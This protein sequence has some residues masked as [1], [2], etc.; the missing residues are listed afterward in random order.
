MEKYKIYIAD[1][2][3][4]FRKGMVRLLQS[5]DNVALV[6]DAENGKELIKLVKEEEPHLVL[7]DLEMPIMDGK[8]ASEYLLGKYEDL[9][10]VV[11][12]MHGSENL[13]YQM[14][15]L[16]IHS[17]LLKNAEPEEVRKAIDAVINNDFY[18][19]RLMREV[20]KKAE[21][22]LLRQK[23]TIGLEELTPREKEIIILI[24]HELTM[25]EIGEKLF[26]SERTVEKHRQ[27][28]MQKLGV[29]NAVGIVKFAFENNLFSAIN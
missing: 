15:Q 29:K 20:I 10:I 3:T 11:L 26:L 2:H 18:Y 22:G 12:S 9:K 8:T 13:V 5:F 28:I 6:K 27:N 24:C 7:M 14:L 1:D 17:Y 21:Q 25:R 4:L 23:S 19:N 16:G